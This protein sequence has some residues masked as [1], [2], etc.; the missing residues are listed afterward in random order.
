M[1]VSR[2][3][4]LVRQE[5]CMGVNHGFTERIF[6]SLQ[7]LD[8]FPQLGVARRCLS[9]RE[10]HGQIERSTKPRVME[11]WVKVATDGTACRSP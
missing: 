9:A 4:E 1:R 6:A 5:S 10:R 11:A 2:L 3:E 7:R 8:K